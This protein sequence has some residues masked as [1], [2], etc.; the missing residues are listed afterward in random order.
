M[1]G[2]RRDSESRLQEQRSQQ[3]ES[4]K[5]IVPGLKETSTDQSQFEVPVSTPSRTVMMRIYLPANFPNEKPVLQ[6][7]AQIRHPWLNTFFQVTGHPMLLS[8]GPHC[9]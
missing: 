5:T 8:W 4:L 7:L 2:R 6:M 9:N 1:F 3:I